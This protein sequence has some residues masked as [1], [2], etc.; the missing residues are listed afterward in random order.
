LLW[1]VAV[2]GGLTSAACAAPCR[3]RVAE[4][5]VPAEYSMEVCSVEDECDLSAD[6]TGSIEPPSV[7]TP[8]RVQI[9]TLTPNGPVTLCASVDAQRWEYSAKSDD[10]KLSRVEIYGE[11]MSS[12]AQN[13]YALGSKWASQW[14][15]YP[16]TAVIAVHPE[17]L[18]EAWQSITG[19]I[20]V[21]L[22]VYCRS[23]I[24]GNTVM[25][26]STATY[27]P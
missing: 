27:P 16:R 1:I 12:S 13:Y 2:I 7:P 22:I 14:P 26:S 11:G 15:T 21:K 6:P 3:H 19:T 8:P 17:D 18:K 20:T 5:K 4:H 24:D 9:R 10:G 23:P 25:T